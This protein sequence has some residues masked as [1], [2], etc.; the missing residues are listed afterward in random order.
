MAGA[1]NQ[2]AGEVPARL[3]QLENQL[4]QAH[5]EVAGLGEELATQMQQ[6]SAAERRAAESLK[7]AAD[8][9]ASVMALQ[10][11]LQSQ[12]QQWKAKLNEVTDTFESRVGRVS[13]AS[14][15]AQ[16]LDAERVEQ[17]EVQLEGAR[18]TIDI[19]RRANACE[20]FRRI[21]ED[22]MAGVNPRR[23]R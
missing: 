12:D 2:H 17:T 5:A 7:E 10:Q 21:I 11:Q 23:A 6:S 4:E 3:Q 18:A 9:R 22:I 14:A 13:V 15:E 16:V 19:L 20:R 1:P 8:G